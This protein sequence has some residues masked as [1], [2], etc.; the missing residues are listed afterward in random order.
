MTSQALGAVQASTQAVAERAGELPVRHG[1]TMA[2]L[3]GLAVKAV[4]E[5]RWQQVASFAERY[6][7]AMGGIVE[8]LYAGE[9][10]PA[11][12]DLIKAGE[13]AVREHV[14]QE[15]RTHGADLTNLWA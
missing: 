2:G 6:D 7:I 8:R 15:F 10:R 14:R 4:Y 11:P 9:E 13:M 12:S 1:Y 3:N 5:A